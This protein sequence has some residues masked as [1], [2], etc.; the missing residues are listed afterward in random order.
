MSYNLLLF[1]LLLISIFNNSYYS[2]LST[3]LFQSEFVDLRKNIDI[4]CHAILATE[5]IS[6]D[7][8]AFEIFK[9]FLCSTRGESL[10]IFHIY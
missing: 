10:K 3:T 6:M 1:V 9:P 5:H 8:K 4:L 2:F 7:F